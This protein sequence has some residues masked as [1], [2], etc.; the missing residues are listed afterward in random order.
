MLSLSFRISVVVRASALPITRTIFTFLC[1][2]RI[3]SRSI[4]RK[5]Q[6]KVGF[7]VVTVSLG[8]LE[9]VDDSSV[10]YSQLY[11]C[12]TLGAMQKTVQTEKH[13]I[14]RT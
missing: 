5:L 8:V 1:N 3:R 2:R 14:L 4:C 10:R 13:L 9:V 7:K 11:I 12:S 6:C